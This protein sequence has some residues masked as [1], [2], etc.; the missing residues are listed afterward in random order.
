MSRR[1]VFAGTF[2]KA[3]FEVIVANMVAF[4][5]RRGIILWMQLMSIHF[6]V[7]ITFGF[8][9]YWLMNKAKDL[10]WGDACRNLV[11]KADCGK[12]YVCTS[13]LSY[14]VHI[15]KHTCTHTI[16]NKEHN[17]PQQQRQQKTLTQSWIQNE[18]NRCSSNNASL[19]SL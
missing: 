3:E 6:I 12:V 10:Q 7:H 11:P 5:L 19:N 2:P 13:L 4:Q 18:A 8:Y 1:P 14:C 17:P 16:F 15:Q 9:I